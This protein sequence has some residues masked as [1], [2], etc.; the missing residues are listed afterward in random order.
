MIYVAGRSS[1]AR[2]TPPALPATVV[3]TTG[4]AAKLCGVKPDTVLKWIKS[5]KLAADRTVGGHFRI[6][7]KSICEFLHRPFSEFSGHTAAAPPARQHLYCWEYMSDQGTIRDECTNCIVYRTHASRC[8]LLAE[9]GVQIGHSRVFCPQDCQDCSYYRRVKGLP[10]RLLVVTADRGLAAHLAG[11]DEQ[12][13]VLRIARNSYEVS[14]A[15]SDFHPAFVVLDWDSLRSEQGL[16]ESL[17]DDPRSP[18]RKVILATRTL[19]SLRR[20]EL[21]RTVVRVIR[22]PFDLRQVV[23]VIESYPVDR[24]LPDEVQCQPAGLAAQPPSQLVLS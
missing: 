17:C 19:A 22:S 3:L 10:T 15:M 23:S 1:A 24:L 8:F 13:V 18:G 20:R 5:G 7:S 6:D 11:E 9:A 4:Q 12:S 21:P 16:L 2:T 14:A